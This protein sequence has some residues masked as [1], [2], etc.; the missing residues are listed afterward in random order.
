MPI[1]TSHELAL[2]TLDAPPLPPLWAAATSPTGLPAVPLVPSTSQSSSQRTSQRAPQPLASRPSCVYVAGGRAEVD[3]HPAP[4]LLPGA[5]FVNPLAASSSPSPSDGTTPSGAASSGA[6]AADAPGG[7]SSPFAAFVER[8]VAGTLEQAILYLRVVSPSPIAALSAPP[9]QA[10]LL[11]LGPQSSSLVV[12]PPGSTGYGAFA[13]ASQA[14]LAP[15][16]ALLSSPVL[17]LFTLPL[18]HYPPGLVAATAA[19]AA[20]GSSGADNY[21]MYAAADAATPGGYAWPTT[22]PYMPMWPRP[23]ATPLGSTASFYGSMAYGGGGFPA[24]APGL[25]GPGAY[26]SLADP[27]AAALLGGGGAPGVLPTGA[28]IA[29]PPAVADPIGQ[30]LLLGGDSARPGAAGA[31]DERTGGLARDRRAIEVAAVEAV[32]VPF[33]TGLLECLRAYARWLHCNPY[34]RA[35]TLSG[36]DCLC[37]P[38][39][40]MARTMKRNAT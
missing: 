35:P 39:R 6:P 38:Q 2:S 11:A 20:P 12:V 21:F 23:G 19:T 25:P 27:Y 5:I 36:A 16:L 13:P 40:G 8:L 32:Q 17:M 18:P 3:T 24:T 34:W 7:A 9:A 26:Y 31:A 15:R 4:A 10:G 30:L 14:R 22:N 37:A 33:V 29:G 28:L 1:Y